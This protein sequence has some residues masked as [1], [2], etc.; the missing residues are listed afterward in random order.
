MQAAGLASGERAAGGGCPS[1][2]NGP[3]AGAVIRA[4]RLVMTSS[5]GLGRG[6][7]AADIHAATASTTSCSTA[8]SGAVTRAQACQYC[9]ARCH[10]SW[11]MAVGTAVDGWSPGESEP[12]NTSGI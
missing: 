4:R 12:L 5:G 6:A 3:A 1:T 8:A 10:A 11:A 7:T 9:T 2:T